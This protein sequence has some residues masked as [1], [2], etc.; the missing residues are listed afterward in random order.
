MIVA[1]GI[2]SSLTCPLISNGKPVG[3][4]FFSS[5]RPYTYEK[6]HVEFFVR[7]AGALATM[8]EKGL[9][10][11]ELV[12]Q[13]AAI[14]T[15][16]EELKRLHDLKNSF[17]GMAA[18]DLRSPLGTI[19]VMT[20]ILLHSSHKLPPDEREQIMVDYLNRIKRKTSHMLLLLDDLL[21]VAQIESGKVGLNLSL[22][23]LKSFLEERVAEH[24]QVA[25]SKNIRLILKE[26]PPAQVKADAIR[27]QQVLDNL[28]SNALKF[29][30]PEKRVWLWLEQIPFGWKICVKDEGPGISEEDRERLFQDFA[31][32]SAKPTGGE[33]STGLGLA[34]ARRLIVAHGGHIGVDSEPGEGASFWFTLPG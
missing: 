6:A 16:N 31:R 14:E 11:S 8:V 23:N 12:E 4:L 13:K 5:A 30:P 28:I 27:L 22:L 29:S 25:S 19:S 9:L 15:K 7:I 34:I 3:F 24:T 26:S 32:L 21:D 18:H 2:R 20:E 33:K 17:L 10:V 1:E